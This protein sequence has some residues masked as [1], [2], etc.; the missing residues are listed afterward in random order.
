MRQI[1]AINMASQPQHSIPATS[2]HAKV[3]PEKPK[4]ADITN[5]IDADP[6]DLRDKPIK[7]HSKRVENFQL[8]TNET[9][10]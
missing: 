4:N 6:W 8:K 3:V 9:F 2:E 1:N 10:S 7:I 5:K